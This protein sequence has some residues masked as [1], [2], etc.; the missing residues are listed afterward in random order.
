MIKNNKNGFSMVLPVQLV[1]ISSTNIAWTNYALF[2]NDR[3]NN[4]KNNFTNTM[5]LDGK[6]QELSS[7]I[8]R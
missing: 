6:K 3:V 5:Q 7:I 1:F 8:K 2:N 4:L